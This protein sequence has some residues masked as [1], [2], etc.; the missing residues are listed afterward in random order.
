M[1]EESMMSLLHGAT[2]MMINLGELCDIQMVPVNGSVNVKKLVNA[3]HRSVSMRSQA[4]DRAQYVSIG[5]GY[6]AMCTYIEPDNTRTPHRP[7][8]YLIE[9][10]PW[11]SSPGKCSNTA[12]A[13]G[14]MHSMSTG[15]IPPAAMIY[16][17]GCSIG[18]S[19][20]YTFV[21]PHLISLKSTNS[22]TI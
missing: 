14:R 1:L 4:V 6:T 19:R 12:L 16:Q 13:E 10:I 21:T 15:P 8:G 9:S 2:K 20:W 3:S 5:T 18:H 17:M 11:G 7:G 22:H